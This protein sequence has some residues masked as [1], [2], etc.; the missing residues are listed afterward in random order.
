[1]Q[2][3]GAVST[4]KFYRNPS[5][6]NANPVITRTLKKIGVVSSNYKGPMPKDGEIWLVEV[7]ADVSEKKSVFILWPIR[8]IDIS[9]LVLLEEGDFES[10][11]VGGYLF[12]V[13]KNKDGHFMLSSRARQNYETVNAIIVLHGL[14]DEN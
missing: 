7:V 5:P 8:Q 2:A 11:M 9:E 6:R 3:I 13:P 4:V 12:A 10:Y 1:M 14:D